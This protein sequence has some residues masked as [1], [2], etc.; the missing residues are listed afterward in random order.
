[1]RALALCLILSGCST[2]DRYFTS[3]SRGDGEIELPKGSN[4]ETEEYRLEV[5]VSG[6]IGAAPAASRPS[7]LPPQPSMNRDASATPPTAESESGIPWEALLILLSGLG[8]G[9]GTRYGTKK[10]RAYKAK[11]K[12][13]PPFIQG[14]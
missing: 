5:G 10:A 3:V 1:M 2:P 13:R 6:A 14:P 11:R 9:E 4:L 12:A 8:L 7:R